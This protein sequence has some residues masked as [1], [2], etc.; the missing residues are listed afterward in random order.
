MFFVTGLRS[1]QVNAQMRNHGLAVDLVDA[2]L[3]AFEGG[4]LGLVGGTGNSGRNHRMALSVYCDEGC[5]LF[6]SLARVAMIR[7]KDGTAEDLMDL[8]RT[9]TRHRVTHNFVDVVLGRAENGSPGEVGWR[10]VELLDAA[11]RSA[12]A[13]GEVVRTEELYQT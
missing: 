2:M 12:A 11:Y 8:P 13:N 7:Q 3:V 1:E 5:L 10:T 4:A 9:W 6:D